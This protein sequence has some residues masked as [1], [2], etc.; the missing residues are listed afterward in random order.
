MQKAKQGGKTIILL[1][2][3]A[4][5]RP[6]LEGE[7][8]E[9]RLHEVFWNS[10]CIEEFNNDDDIV[11]LLSI[12][13]FFKIATDEFPTKCRE[14]HSDGYALLL[15]CSKQA[16]VINAV[17]MDEKLAIEL[18]FRM[19]IVGSLKGLRPARKCAYQSGF[20]DIGYA[21]HAIQAAKK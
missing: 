1:V 16:G 6:I 9:T 3:T 5:S 8:G 15:I 12:P 18:S 11:I 10:K 20:Y 19:R 4:R 13:C 2:E 14:S 7:T 17:R 21:Q